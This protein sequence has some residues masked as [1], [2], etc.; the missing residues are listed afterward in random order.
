MRNSPK[1]PTL[2]LVVGI[3][4]GLHA[5]YSIGQSDG[6][7]TELQLG[8]IAA[9]ISLA[10][11]GVQG[12]ISVVIE[13]QEL[14]PGRTPARLTNSLSIGIALLSLL[15]IVVAGLLAFGIA[16]DW[17][18]EAVGTLA[19]IG[20]IAISLLLVFYKEAYIGDEATFDDRQDGVPW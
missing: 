16:A 6:P 10:I 20:S 19:G 5:T 14:H 15:L 13:G 4:L 2:S 18:L 3:L 1:L 12:L 8:E 17:R 9:A 11:F 7:L